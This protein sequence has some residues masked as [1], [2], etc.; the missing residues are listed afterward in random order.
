ML[1]LNDPLRKE[2]KISNI[3]CTADLKQ[4]VDI[5]SFNNYKFLDSNLELY[6]CG[7]VKDDEMI[8]RVTVF[9]NGKLISV[10]TKS[11]D[12]AVLELKKTSKILQNYG[13]INHYKISPKVRNIVANG[14]ITT[15]IDL[16][17]FAR[18]LPHCIYEPEQFSGLI[19]RIK[20]SIVALIFASGKII[21][22][23][24]KT[25]KELNSAF[26]ELKQR[27]TNSS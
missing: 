16:H 7:Y 2:L 17:H 23:G 14:I 12:E 3:V 15:K 10:G 9:G 26:F 8:G 13:L 27:L 18:V 21:L 19:Y 4:S 20:D 6:R 22:V 5:A 1:R 24:S 25:I 11:P